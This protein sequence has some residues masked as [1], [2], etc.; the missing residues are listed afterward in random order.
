M[1]ALR[2]KKCAFAAF[3][4]VLLAGA[5]YVLRAPILNLPRPSSHPNAQ[6]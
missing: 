3:A 1:S 6:G 5:L 2:L 4:A